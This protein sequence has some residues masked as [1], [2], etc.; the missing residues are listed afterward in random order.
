MRANGA[1]G[2]LRPGGWRVRLC[3]DPCLG[4]LVLG[5]L[6]EAADGGNGPPG[7]NPLCF[8]VLRVCRLWRECVR[9]VLRTQRSVTWISAGVA[10]AGHLE[11]HCLVR[12]VAEAL[13]ASMELCCGQSLAGLVGHL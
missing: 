4:V 1:G 8:C 10:E 6:C 2:D 3:R 11:G 5:W 12:V 9:R 13:E 7:G